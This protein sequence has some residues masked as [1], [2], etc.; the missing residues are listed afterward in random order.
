MKKLFLILFAVLF[1]FMCGCTADMLPEN[2]DGNLREA[3]GGVDHSNKMIA[4]GLK[5]IPDTA[6]EIPSEWR[7]LLIRYD[8]YYLGSTTGK[9]LYLTFDEGY[10]NGFTGKI[11]DVL[12]R[13]GVPAAFF[14]T[15]YYVKTQPEL[16]KRM[17]DE[18]HII[19]NHTV[20]HPS[21]PSVAD[22]TVLLKEL[23]EL[24]ES[25]LAI[26]G[27][28]MAFLRPPKGEMSERTL[29]LSQ[30]AGYKTVLW[31]SAYADW[32]TTKFK[33]MDY[34]FNKVTEQFHDGSIILLHAVSKDN[35]DALENIINMAWLEGYT[36]L[37]LNDL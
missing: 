28:R 14:V 30:K 6:P 20:N 34:A 11:L 13:T 16:I 31:S 37:S 35:A 26:T 8:G 12:K 18:G 36:F 32:D 19:G 17:A 29:A 5:K 21:M 9:N 22:D 25:C 1:I 24:E 15:G 4:W 7:E 10:E 27:Q 2:D 3:A 23:S 33:G